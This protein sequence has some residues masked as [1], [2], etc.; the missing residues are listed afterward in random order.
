MPAPLIRRGGRLPAAPLEEHSASPS[1]PAKLNS[2][3]YLLRSRYVHA[4]HLSNVLQ[5][6]RPSE[7]AEPADAVRAAMVAVLID[8]HV[9]RQQFGRGGG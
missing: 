9:L 5:F 3:R 2:S 7:W 6:L 1:Q 8:L 4:Q